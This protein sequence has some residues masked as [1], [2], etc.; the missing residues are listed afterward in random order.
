[1]YKPKSP[2]NGYSASSPHIGSTSTLLGKI[3]QIMA[4]LLEWSALSDLQRGLIEIKFF[5]LTFQCEK[6]IISSMVGAP[7]KGAYVGIHGL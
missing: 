3:S 6:C 2:D 4:P 5:S 1:M 7:Q